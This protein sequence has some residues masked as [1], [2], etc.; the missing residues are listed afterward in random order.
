MLFTP[1]DPMAHGAALLG[2]YTWIDLVKLM[3]LSTG[4]SPL[5]RVPKSISALIN[6]HGLYTLV[7]FIHWHGNFST[8]AIN[9]QALFHRALPC[10]AG[11]SSSINFLPSLIEMVLR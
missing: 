7:Q 4:V 5:E 2:L 10:N 3:L 1:L 6:Q 11:E 8:G 9:C